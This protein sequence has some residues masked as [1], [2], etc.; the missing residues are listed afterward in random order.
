MTIKT[1]KS[2]HLSWR[3]STASAD[4]A[5]KVA[6]QSKTHSSPPIP[7]GS[8]SLGLVQIRQESVR[9]QRWASGLHGSPPVHLIAYTPSIWPAPV[10]RAY[11][12]ADWLFHD[13]QVEDILQVVG[14]LH[15]Q[16]AGRLEFEVELEQSFMF[17]GQ[18]ACRLSQ[19]FCLTIN[20][21]FLLLHIIAINLWHR[22]YF[23]SNYRG[24]LTSSDFTISQPRFWLCL[25]STCLILQLLPRLLCI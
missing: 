5:Y 20:Q 3:L 23:K 25:L 21:S 24:S 18:F 17:H 2:F 13:L 10:S 7:C 19:Q 22:T 4:V 14:S 11:N 16:E 9:C 6:D 1:L 15:R 8:A 12:L